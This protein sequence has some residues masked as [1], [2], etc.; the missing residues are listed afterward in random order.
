MAAKE[1]PGVLAGSRLGQ[2]ARD[3]VSLWGRLFK[4]HELLSYASNIARTMLVASVSIL[5]LLLGVA[6]AIGREDL[7]TTHVAPQIRDRVLPDVYS[8]VNQTVDRIF[9]ANPP[10]LI[11]FAALLAVWEVSGSVR[12][13]SG[14][15]NR[16]YGT[17][18]T[19]SRKRRYLTSFGLAL[20]VN[21]AL[22]TAIMLAMA[23]GG[24]VH[25]A[26]SVPFAIARWLA[27]VL[28]IATAF[29]LLVRFAPAQPRAKT[30]TSIGAVLVVIGWIVESLAFKWYI[31]T[32]AN[33]RNAVG[34][35]TVVLVV[36]SYL[37]FASIILL[38]G[39]EVD[40]LLRENVDDPERTLVQFAQRLR[41]ARDKVR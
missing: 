24:A 39:I 3:S 8:G 25:G 5:L 15:L 31:G 21:V 20:V 30:W 10:G 2:W 17:E 6:A 16:I 19:R 32:L 7:W 14:A 18:E 4:E 37:Y 1:S 23:V 34:S 36:I 27:A 41:G 22:L 35:L 13:V 28:L 40:E 33:F 29:G 26:A 38:V 12:G 11:A 9:A